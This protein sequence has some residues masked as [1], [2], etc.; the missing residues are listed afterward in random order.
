VSRQLAQRTARPSAP[1]RAGSIMY[2][3]AHEGQTICMA[4]QTGRRYPSP[5]GYS[6]I[7]MVNGA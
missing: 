3:L 7:E 6:L 4:N 2:S 5:S 1:I